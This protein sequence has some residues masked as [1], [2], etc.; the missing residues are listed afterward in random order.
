[1][2]FCEE[3]GSMCLSDDK[4]FTEGGGVLCDDC[5]EKKAEDER[6][7]KEQLESGEHFIT[8]VY[9]DDVDFT[10]LREQRTLLDRLFQKEGVQETDNLYGVLELLDSML[11]EAEQ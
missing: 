2:Y 5:R 10:L 8:G 3:C 4:H 7:Q 6:K 1:M 11:D 9:L